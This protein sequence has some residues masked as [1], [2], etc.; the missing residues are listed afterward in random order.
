MLKPVR[1]DRSD[2]VGSAFFGAGGEIITSN[3]WVLS[4]ELLQ[5]DRLMI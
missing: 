1:E 5:E 2:A 4:L 3:S